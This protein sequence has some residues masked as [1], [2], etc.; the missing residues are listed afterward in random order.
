MPAA[1]QL[2]DQTARTPAPM[3]G[4]QVADHSLNLGA[5][6]PRMRLRR[7]GTVSQP[8]Q[9]ALA[10]TGH[11]PVHRLPGHP[12][13]LRDLNDRSAVKDLKDGLVPLLDHVQL[14]KHCG[15]VAHQVKPRCRTSS[16]A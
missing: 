14:P 11:P 4:P 8:G 15:S 2:E 5:D 6:P 3:S 7:V 12:E 1:F 13:P 9:S 10:V 16:G